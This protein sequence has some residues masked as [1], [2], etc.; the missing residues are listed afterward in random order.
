MVLALAVSLLLLLLLLDIEGL[1]H[2]SVA[3]GTTPEGWTEVLR[4]RCLHY[5][6][7]GMGDN[8]RGDRDELKVA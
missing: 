7:D 4:S 3:T 8:C 1:Q 2:V 5:H 6:F